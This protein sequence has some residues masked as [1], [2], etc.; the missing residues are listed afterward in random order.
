MARAWIEVNLDAVAVNYRA[1]VKLLRPGSRCMAV[2]KAD[3]YGLGAV[4]VALR[5]EECGCEAFAV[6]SVEEGLVLREHGIKGIILVLGPSARPEWAAAVSSGLQLSISDQA[7]IA[8]LDDLAGKQ[9]VRAEIH[10]KLETG[11]GRTGFPP[12]EVEE[13]ASRLRGAKNLAV[14]GVYTHF[15]RAAQRDR[16]YTER[17]YKVFLD[18]TARLASAGVRPQWKHVCNSAAFLEFPDWHLDFVRLG[19]LLVGHLP[20][21]GF[22]G[23]ITLRDP[24]TAKC[25][26]LSV[27]RVAKGTYVGY[28][29]TYRTGADTQLAVIP[30]GYADGFGL[31]PR[32][33]PQGWVDL[34]KI[35]IKNFALMFGVVLGREKVSLRGRTV[36][37]AGKIGMQ[38]TVLD[39]GLDECLPG[40]EVCLPLRRTSANPRLPRLYLREGRIFAERRLKEG[41]SRVDQEYPMLKDDPAGMKGKA[42]TAD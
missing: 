38:L 8:E 39:V 17:Q 24:W 2:V 16:T 29:S 12:A 36:R 7:S 1:A 42:Y 5:L 9:G 31:E 3:G 25:R 37:V 20:G 13:L 32:L 14:M 10:L 22:Q 40:D 23:R 27:R 26:V 35:F 18:G 15:A 41:F 34:L 30:V 6:T 11:M 33:V 4:Q 28:Q 19:T 21:V